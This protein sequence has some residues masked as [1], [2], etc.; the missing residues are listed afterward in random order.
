MGKQKLFIED[1]DLAGKLCAVRVDFNVPV[2]NGKVGD[3]KRIRAAL[4]TIRKLREAGARTFLMTHLGRPKGGPEDKYRLAPVAAHLS[5]LLGSPVESLSDCIGPEVDARIAA[6]KNGET[7]LLE[8]VRFYAEEEK[9]NADF[10]RKLSHGAD[11]FIN[12]A[13][14]TAHRAHASTAGIAA[15]VQRSACG[16]LIRDELKYLGQA[17]SNPA[18]PY[19]AISGGAKISG[20]IDLMKNLLPN[21]DTLIVG[22]GMTFTFLKAQG[23]EIGKSLLEADKVSLAGELLKQGGS[24]LALPSDFQVSTEFDFDGGKVGALKT[25][26][27]STIPADS[28]GLDIGPASVEAFRKIL[29]AAKTIVWNGPMGVFEIDATAKGTFAIAQ[30]LADAT[31]AGATTI[32]GG[33]DSAAAIEKAGL[34][35]KVSFVSTGG[36]A[37]LEFL[38]G[39]VLPGVDCLSDA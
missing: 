36:G 26:S 27:D 18:R 32:I 15:Y 25:V 7:I 22:G 24:K 35:S 28:Y 14:G 21:V 1:L 16:Y 33:G 30:A 31:A 9:N 11:Y 3:D 2:K 23:K 29:L 19:V 12:D 34:S 13:F 5:Q 4:P 38:E 6:M 20:K 39:R 10:A 17:L 37:T 8:N